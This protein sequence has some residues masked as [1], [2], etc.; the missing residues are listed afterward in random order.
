MANITTSIADTSGFIP[1]AW[2][3]RA[4]DVLRANMVLATLITKDSDFEPGWQ[5]KQ[6]NIPYPGTF[7]AQSKTP[8]NPATVQTPS[9][10]ASVPV[11]LDNFE[12]VDFIVEDVAQAQANTQL[13]DR[14][15]KPA[16]IALGNKVE[17]DI[18]D[19]YA[20]FDNSI[21]TPGT[22]L[23]AA[24]TR[25]ARKTLNDELVPPS[26]RYLV[27]SPKDEIALLG[28]SNLANYFAFAQNQG[29]SEGSLGKLYGFDVRLSQLAPV[30]N[31]SPDT[32]YNLAFHPE[33][34]IMATR[35]FSEIPAGAGVSV[36]TVQDPDTGLIIRVLAQYDITN[37]GMR[38]GFD[39][40]YG[41]KI[42]RNHLAVAVAT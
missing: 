25:T 24:L 22:D 9:G 10:G 27:I 5:G 38:V 18:W 37:R 41:V 12:Y 33:A 14:Y 2:A 7:T 13:M 20:D 30:V 31:G 8:N 34:M 11:T 15:L 17:A 40:L 29:V 39:I 32:T 3:Q 26:P 21:G 4:L 42:L 35:P 19:L 28:D 1:E 16:V 36:S 6:L 23:T